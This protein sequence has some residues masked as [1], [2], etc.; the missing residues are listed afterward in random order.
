MRQQ[1]IDLPAKNDQ[2]AEAM[3]GLRHTG[4][5][6]IQSK[7]LASMGQLSA[8]VIHEIGNPLNYSNQ[9]LFLLRKLLGRQKE[10]PQVQEAMD[11]IQDSFDRIKTIVADLREFSHKSM[12][13]RIEFNL[14]D[15]VK[16]AIRMLGKEFTDSGI[17]L[18]LEHDPRFRTDAVKN[19]ITQVF[20]NLIHNSLQALTESPRPGRIV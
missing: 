2:L 7:K 15:S 4:G 16:V 17:V 19:Q 20:V 6:L 11:D 12:V 8:G 18:G 10:Q 1:K 5:Q 13:T 3:N 14:V 9:A